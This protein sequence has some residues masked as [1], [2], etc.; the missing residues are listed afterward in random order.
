MIA[1]FLMFFGTVLLIHAGYSA[2]QYKTLAYSQGKENV[3]TLPPA[4]ILIECLLSF[5]FI[6]VGQM[7]PLSLES[8]QISS[9]NKFMAFADRFGTPDY[10]RSFHR[11]REFQKR[12]TRVTSKK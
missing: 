1:K 4:D 9:R 7:M 5:I 11:G 2:N 8:I 3:S 10:S 12:M 6:V